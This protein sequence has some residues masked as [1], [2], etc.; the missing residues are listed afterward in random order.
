MFKKGTTTTDVKKSQQK[1]IDLKRDTPTRLKHLKTVLENPDVADTKLFLDSNFSV[2]FHLFYEAFITAEGNLKQ[3]GAFAV[4]R[5]H[6]EDLENC[7]FFLDRI[8]CLL[9]ELLKQ[10]WQCNS[11]THIFKKLLHPNNTIRLKRESMRLFLLWYMIVGENKTDDMDCLFA[12]LIDGFPIPPP[13]VHLIDS[14]GSKVS[15]IEPSPIITPS[16]TEKTPE[17]IAA[18]MLKYFLEFMVSQVRRVEWKDKINQHPKAFSYVLGRFR[19]I[20]LPYIFPNFNPKNSI[21]KPNLELPELRTSPS[22]NQFGSCPVVLVEWIK[23]HISVVPRKQEN[24]QHTPSLGE[25]DGRKS[26]HSETGHETSNASDQDSISSAFYTNDESSALEDLKMVREILFSSREN[27]D[28]IHEVF[29]QALRLC[30]RYSSAMKA[31]IH[32]YCD[33]IKMTSPELPPF[34]LEPNEGGRGESDPEGDLSRRLRNDSY[35]GAMSTELHV[36]A[37]LQNVLQVF[38]TSAANVF[39]LVVSPDYARLLD[40]QVDLCKLVLNIYRYMVMNSRMEQKT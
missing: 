18:Y 39:L 34:M 9:P 8:L 37:G 4:Q 19:Y 27:V 1:C 28:F 36:R 38:V 23:K 31:V 3:K 11:L 16:S 25:E 17:D 29:R 35:I 30:F 21:Y 5:S 7:L 10:R 26:A 12:S 2:V 6:R 24:L 22:V 32:C 14:K 15:W 40:E 33:W 20:Y 13:P